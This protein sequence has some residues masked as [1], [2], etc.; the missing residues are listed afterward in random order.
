MPLKRTIVVLNGQ[1]LTSHPAISAWFFDQFCTNNKRRLLFVGKK[2]E[3]LQCQRSGFSIALSVSADCELCIQGKPA[4]F[5]V[6]IAKFNETLSSGMVNIN[7]P[8]Y[9]SRFPVQC[10]LMLFQMVYLPAYAVCI[11][12]CAVY[13]WPEVHHP[14]AHSPDLHVV[15]H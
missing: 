9:D 13:R 8:E 7:R 10:G 11:F 6:V 15:R 14:K 2:P 12:G 5:G 1:M 3:H 4:E